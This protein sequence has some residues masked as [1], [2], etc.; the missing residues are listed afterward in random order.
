[1]KDEEGNSW[2]LKKEFT[3]RM[4]RNTDDEEENLGGDF[5]GKEMEGWDRIVQTEGWSEA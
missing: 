1:M 4:R 2:E 3:S 5:H